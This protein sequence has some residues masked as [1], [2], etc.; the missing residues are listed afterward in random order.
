MPTTSM[1]DNTLHAMRQ[2]KYPGLLSTLASVKADDFLAL[3][4]PTAV[5]V[6]AFCFVG[7][8]SLTIENDSVEIRL[9]FFLNRAYRRPLT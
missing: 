8:H 9:I 5:H 1:F 4:C 7:V 6:L 3:Q 2:H